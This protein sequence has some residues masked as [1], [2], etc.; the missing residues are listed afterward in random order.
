MIKYNYLYSVRVFLQAYK[1]EHM[2]E[3]EKS[4]SEYGK[5]NINF[6]KNI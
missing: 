2:S 6:S 4:N 5:T 1:G 3:V